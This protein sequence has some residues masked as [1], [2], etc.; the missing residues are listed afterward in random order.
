[1]GSVDTFQLTDTLQPIFVGD[2]DHV[3][4][5]HCIHGGENGTAP[6]TG[7]QHSV[8][9]RVG[10]CTVGKDTLPGSN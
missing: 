1:M 6:S 5:S 8:R 2:G 3:L 4:S 7:H 10:T 9:M